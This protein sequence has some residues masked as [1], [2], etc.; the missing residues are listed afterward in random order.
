MIYDLKNPGVILHC[1]FK[2]N[3]KEMCNVEPRRPR[4]HRMPLRFLFSLRFFDISTRMGPLLPGHRQAR[5]ANTVHHMGPRRAAGQHI[6]LFYDFN[7]DSVRFYNFRILK[8]PVSFQ[9]LDFRIESKD[10]CNAQPIILRN[11][12]NPLFSLCFFGIS[13]QR[14]PLFPGRRQSR[15]APEEQWRCTFIHL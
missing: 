11:H 9:I 5:W 4:N 13:I 2:T 15:W 3:P 14:G 10:M 1:R 7:W 8:I 6:L 12:R